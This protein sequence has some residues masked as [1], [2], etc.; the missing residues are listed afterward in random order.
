M[1]IDL[2]KDG[3]TSSLRDDQPSNLHLTT[4]IMANAMLS[5]VESRGTT[6]PPL[7][8]NKDSGEYFHNNMMSN[9]PDS[10]TGLSD[11]HIFP[12]L[13]P[14]QGGTA[15]GVGAAAGGPKT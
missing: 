8:S 4:D 10:P 13:S 9:E 15:S 6:L 3:A 14:T 1:N 5:G 2:L 11:H 12:M 7:A